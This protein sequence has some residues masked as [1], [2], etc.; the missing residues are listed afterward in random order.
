M[1]FYIE[2]I[3]KGR[4]NNMAY[5]IIYVCNSINNKN[6]RNGELEILRK[7]ESKLCFEFGENEM[8]I[9]KRFYNDLETL[10]KDFEELLKLKEDSENKVTENEEIENKITEDM[11]IARENIQEIAENCDLKVS[12]ETVENNVESNIKNMRNNK[13]INKRSKLL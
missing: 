6:V 11:S 9:K 3:K 5:E 12:V 4:K 13:K 7:N 8:N 1:K 2:N 10:N